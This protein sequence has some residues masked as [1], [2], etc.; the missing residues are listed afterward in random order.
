[1]AFSAAALYLLNL[2]GVLSLLF[3]AGA[4]LLAALAARFAA[5]YAA[6]LLAHASGQCGSGSILVGSATGAAPALALAALALGAA[7]WCGSFLGGHLRHTPTRHPLLARAALAAALAGCCALGELG[8]T[9]PAELLANYWGAQRLSAREAAG[10][11]G[12]TARAWRNVFSPSPLLT[13]AWVLLHQ[14]CFAAFVVGAWAAH[15]LLALVLGA[16]FL[17][18]PRLCCG[19]RKA[20]GE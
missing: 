8:S 14:R 15:A 18:G 3:G 7:A 10:L 4:A 12:D 11:L 6:A 13:G 20:H 5:A 19:A 2:L 1:L 16:A 17:W 9:P